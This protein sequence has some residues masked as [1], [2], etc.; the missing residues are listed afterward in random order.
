M[1]MNNA[2]QNI[3][4]RFIIGCGRIDR[5]DDAAGLLVVRRLRKRGVPA[6][7]HRGEF[8]TLIDSWRVAESVVLIDAV[9]TG[10]AA[11][12][13]IIWDASSAPLPIDCFKSSTHS[14]GIA[15]AIELARLLGCL[16][17][18]LLIYGIE[19]KQFE[20]G[21]PPSSPVLQAIE[22]VTQK[23]VE[24]LLTCRGVAGIDSHQ[25]V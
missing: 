13:V 14:L 2:K 19:G 7:E 6:C 9:V 17:S 23:I 15:Q 20:I 24:Q 8:L 22:R 3:D 18:R 5:G 12:E 4:A 10:A 1:E 11:G 25:K 16:P 21:A